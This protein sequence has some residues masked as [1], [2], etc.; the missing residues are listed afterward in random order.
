MLVAFGLSSARAQSEAADSLR[1]QK[2]Y[3]R[4]AELMN[5]T[6]QF[7]LSVGL[8]P[9]FGGSSSD[10]PFIE[11]SPIYGVEYSYRVWNF[12]EVGA[13]VS[14]VGYRNFS[15]TED[16]RQQVSQSNAL[17]FSL[18]AR[19]SWFN[20]KWVSLYSSLGMWWQFRSIKEMATPDVRIYQCSA[21]PRP[22]IVPLGIRVGRRFFGFL[23]PFCISGRGILLQGG[24]GYKF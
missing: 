13:S 11:S 21:I 24:F 22:E 1:I 6:S 16:V 2:R 15:Y 17:N 9:N 20:R 4:R 23:E 12:L 7:R 14:Q 3:E 19:Y 8:L 18:T 10:G 5:T